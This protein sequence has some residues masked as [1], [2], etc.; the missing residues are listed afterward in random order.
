[1]SMIN[2]I[3]I[4]GVGSFYDVLCADGNTIRCKARGVF[5]KQHLTPTIG[6]HVLIEQQLQ[7]YAFLKEILPRKNILVRP[8]VA[9]IDRIFIVISATVPQPDWLLLD[10]MIIQALNLGIDPV[11]VMNKTDGAN[12]DIIHT[13]LDDYRAFSPICVS[14]K[15]GDGLEFLRVKMY[16]IVSCFAGQSAVGKSSILNSLFPHLDLATG[17]VSE[18]TE[19]GRHTTRHAELLPFEGGAV[20]DTPGFS[21]FDPAPLEQ[22]ELNSC[23]PEFKNI[24]FSCRYPDC[25]HDTEPE[26]GVKELVEEGGMS[27]NRY[28]RYLIIANEHKNRRKHKYD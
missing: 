20:L 3:L 11:P 26:C 17:D 22:H 8:P 10:Q 23:Y 5:R 18:K 28:E 16:G 13:F 21:L 27:K 25:M 6:D 4:K 15:T 1:M 9:N 12:T 24:P 7:G 2:G 14:A 19:H